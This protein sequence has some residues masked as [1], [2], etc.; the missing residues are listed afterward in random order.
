MMGHQHSSMGVLAILLGSLVVGSYGCQADAPSP[1]GS[2]SSSPPAASALAAASV[3]E[4]VKQA[5]ATPPAAAKIQAKPETKPE[6]KPDAKPAAEAVAAAIP[7]PEIEIDVTEAP[8][9]A[10]YGAKVKAEMLKQYPMILKHLGDETYKPVKLVKV[11]FKNMEGVAYASGNQITCSVDWFKK[12]PHDIG[13]TIH[14][15][16]HVVQSYRRKGPPSWVT[17]GVA[18]YVRWFNYEPVAKRPRVNP[19]KAKYTDSYQTTAAFFDW[20]V[21]TKDNG[22]TP[23]FVTKLNAANRQGLYKPE[24][25]KEY[26]GKTLDELWAEFIESVKA[27]REKARQERATKPKPEDAKNAK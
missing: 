7:L 17:E 25:F 10:E 23:H 16:C 11:R 3:D 13:A 14:E 1:T 27:D 21:R 9:M 4:P 22:K 8:E 20:I 2:V 15:L 6:T 24:L 5:P 18:D 26:T 12:R 19:D